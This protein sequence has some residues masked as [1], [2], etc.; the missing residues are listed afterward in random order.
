MRRG[1]EDG[2][3]TPNSGG[4]REGFYCATQLHRICR[5][6]LLDMRLGGVRYEHHHAATRGN[7]LDERKSRLLRQFKPGLSHLHRLHAGGVV[8]DENRFSV[9]E[10]C[11]SHSRTRHAQRQ[12]HQK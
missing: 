11:T 3:Q 5:E 1:I 2:T 4:G 6:R 12:Q 8:N 9:H 10:P 7:L